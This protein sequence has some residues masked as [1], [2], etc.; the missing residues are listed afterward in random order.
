MTD[1][2][3]FREGDKLKGLANYYVWALKMRA[4]LKAEGQWAITETQQEHIEFP[5]RIDG[6]I[7]NEAQLKKR[8]MQTCR[9]I[10]LSV[11]DDLIDLVAECSDPTAMWQTLKNQFNAG[12]QSQVL[13][14]MGQLQTIKMTEGGSIEEYTKKAR[15]L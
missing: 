12:D 15:E 5:V 13:T 2:L 7:F 6:E 14:F 1:S 8:K 9:L 3:A 10:L 4:V 11:V